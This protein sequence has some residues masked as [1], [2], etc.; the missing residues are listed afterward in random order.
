MRIEPI[1]LRGD[2]GQ[3]AL[4]RAQAGR[5]RGD[6]PIGNGEDDDARRIISGIGDG[7]LQADCETARDTR[8]RCARDIDC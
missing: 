8:L 2:A 3:A 7:A 5:K 4:F 6:A 1:D